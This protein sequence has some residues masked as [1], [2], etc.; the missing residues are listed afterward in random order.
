MV[1]GR[2]SFAR[3]AAVAVAGASCL[4][5]AACGGPTASSLSAAP[6]ASST[7][8]PLA[9]LTVAQLETKVIADAKAASSVT[10]KGTSTQSGDTATFN[11][12]TKPGQG[13][14]GTLDL[15]SKGSVKITEIGSTVYMNPDNK[16]WEAVSGTE[17]Q[18]VIALVGGRYIKVSATDKDMESL[19]DLCDVSQMFETNGKKD[20]VTKGKVTTRNGIRVLALNDLTDGSTGYVTDTSD[21]RLI[22]IAAPKDSK[23]GAQNAT[24]TYDAPVTLTAPPA[25]QVIDGSKL[26][27]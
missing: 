10:L 6:S 3:V 11:I 2:L 23:G 17:A 15:G 14:T 5:A 9:G 22:A 1:S 18:Q 24:V 7:V 27:M 19:A 16:Y 12:A 21:P 25:S 20:T 26:G 13:C 4:A 8:D